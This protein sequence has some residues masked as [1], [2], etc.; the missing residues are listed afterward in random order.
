MRTFTFLLLTLILSVSCTVGPN[1]KR[2]HPNSATGA[3]VKSQSLSH[4]IEPG[5]Q[6]D[7]RPPLAI[8]YDWLAEV[9]S[10]GPGHCS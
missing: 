1:Y 2:P 6:R 8:P 5:L 7:D 10:L 3:V 4:G 9:R